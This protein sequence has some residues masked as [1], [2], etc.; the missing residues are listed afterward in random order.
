MPVEPACTNGPDPLAA[1]GD[2]PAARAGS[3]T[4]PRE[5]AGPGGAVEVVGSVTFSI[6]LWAGGAVGD[7]VVGADVGAVVVDEV[8]GAGVVVAGRAVVVV[9]G[10]A[11]VVV[12]GTFVVVVGAVVVGALVVGGAV[13]VGGAMVVGAVV[14][15]ADAAAARVVEVVLAA[16]E[17]PGA[18]AIAGTVTT[19]P[20][21]PATTQ[22]STT[23]RP[24]VTALF[25]D[26]P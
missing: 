3:A 23:L 5:L 16:A 7:D 20:S 4:D 19:P 26:L 22:A 2:T 24:A 11:V 13:V 6:R 25:I 9:A 8:V 14:V 18:V 17:S 15:G 10:G 12:A 1:P 21:D